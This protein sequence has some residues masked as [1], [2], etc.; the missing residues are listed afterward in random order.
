MER[1]EADEDWTLM[2]PDKCPGM[3]DVYGEDFRKL[4][5][6]YE[7]K[8]M[9][10]KTM[11]ARH[12]WQQI[13]EAQSETGTP[14]MLFKDACNQKSNQQNLGTI[15]SSNLCAEVIEY[16][17]EDEVAVCNLASVALPSCISEDG[18]SYDFEKLYDVTY[19][20][21]KNLDR[22]I[23]LNYYPIRQARTSNQR[24]RPVGLGVTGLADVFVMLRMPYESPE[25]QQLNKDI[26]ET[27]YF[28]AVTASKDL[29]KK[30]GPYETYQGSPMSKGI[31]QFDMWNVTPSPRWNWDE[32]REEIAT[33]GV[34]N[35]LSLSLMPTASTG[36]IMGLNECFEAFTRNIY[37]RS[38]QAGDFVVFNKH[39]VN[40]L[41]ALG[42]WTPQIIQK[43]IAA[44]GS[45]QNLDELADRPDIKA[46]YKTVYEMKVKPLIDMSADRGAYICQS[47]SFNLHV[48]HPTTK[49]LH[50]I[51]MYSWKKGLKTGMYYLRTQAAV[52]AIQFTVEATLA[53]EARKKQLGFLDESSTIVHSPKPLPRSSADEE[54]DQKDGTTRNE[55]DEPTIEDGEVTASMTS[56]PQ[57]YVC[58]G[59]ACT[60]CGV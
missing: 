12:L 52:E 31:F 48:A 27:M 40:D 38:T 8:G 1:V 56:M 49:L 54:D 55:D 59:D 6:E 9:G 5:T 3:Q 60:S 58:S 10:N 16:T 43:L 33:H 14:Y 53:Q 36:Q 23:D 32:L 35:S 13:L 17:S 22:V 29:A 20:A 28:A 41:R 24:H 15:R 11:K 19:W 18:K 7:S 39:M 21:A 47:Q 25:A 4:Y 50:N 44:Q 45:V 30:H 26:F 37:V 2:C 34:R 57:G 51:H 46:L 42:L